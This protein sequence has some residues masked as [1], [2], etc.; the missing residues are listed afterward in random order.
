MKYL[1]RV[2]AFATVAA[3]LHGT[4]VSADSGDMRELPPLSGQSESGANAVSDDGTVVVGRA[5]PGLF[6]GVATGGGQATRWTVNG[7]L[8]VEVIN[9]PA[10]VG[11][12]SIP[13]AISSDGQIS[14]G[15]FYD[16][17]DRLNYRFGFADFGLWRVW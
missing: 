17:K 14:A 7:S 16:G 10:A 6:L 15:Y 3:V 8:S 2:P 4:S 12:L 11:E 9:T 1:K 5:G 13:Y